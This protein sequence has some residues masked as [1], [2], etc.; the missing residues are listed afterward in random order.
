M[1]AE[2][3]GGRA[4]ALLDTSYAAETPEGIALSL[5]PAGPVPR[6]LAFM[7]DTGIRIGLW[8]VAVI[9]FGLLGAAG[10]APKLLA[11]FVIEWIYPI[12]YEL[13]PAGATPGKRAF[14]L[15]VVMDS[16][17]PVTPAASVTRNL[18]RVADFL[19]ALYAFG[20]LAV[21]A[22]RDFK[23]LGD[24]AAGTLVVHA[25]PVSLHSEFP[26]APALAPPRPLTRREQAAVLSWAGRAMTLTAE[27]FTELARLARPLLAG[28]S[29]D[30]DAGEAPAAGGDPGLDP[31]VRRLL[32]VA[33]WLAGKREAGPS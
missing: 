22:R 33:H 26:P 18:L 32:G 17:L 10:G 19:P 12:V 31:D 24:L 5:S 13:M 2:A 11:L 14:G 21:L 28:P 25:R 6:A 16:G 3:A 4:P 27:R 8:I 1:S 23:R 20:A 15:Q 9:I 7:I 29:R 30:P